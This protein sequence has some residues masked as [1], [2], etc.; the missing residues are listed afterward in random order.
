[1][2]YYELFMLL[3]PIFRVLFLI[4]T[5]IVTLYYRIYLLDI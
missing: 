4:F 2:L 3:G 1:M 5:F